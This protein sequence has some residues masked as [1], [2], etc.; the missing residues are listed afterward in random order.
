MKARKGGEGRTQ[1][2]T[3][4]ERGSR[5]GSLKGYRSLEWTQGRIPESHHHC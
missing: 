3:H 5:E 4:L 2:L 1:G